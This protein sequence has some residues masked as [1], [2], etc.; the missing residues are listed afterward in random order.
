ML[1]LIQTALRK[2]VEVR[3]RCR[4]VATILAVCMV[5]CAAGCNKKQ[6]AAQEAPGAGAAGAGSQAT[7]TPSPTNSPE[8]AATPEKAASEEKASKPVVVPTG[9]VLTV[10][11]GQAV[12]SKIS[13]TGDTFTATLSEPVS[14]DGKTVIPSGAEASGTVTNAKPLGRFKG[15]AALAL[16]L[17]SITVHGVKH[18]ARTTA[19]VES[20]T[21]KGK[22][23]ATMIGGGAGLGALIG[24]LAG[25]GKGAAIG[26]IAGAGAGTAGTAFTGNKDIVLPAESALRFKLTG[27]LDLGT[28]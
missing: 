23:T 1:V 11:L 4:F 26:A 7:A 27:P 14:V 19:V 6:E 3:M 22:R 12:G 25:G 17:D 24:G 9:T 20:A 28:R 2:I 8:G 5:M 16:R 21:G 13:N 18:A 10:R 15:G